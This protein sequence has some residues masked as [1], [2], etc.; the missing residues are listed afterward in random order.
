MN[1]EQIKGPEKDEKKLKHHFYIK[2][3]TFETLIQSTKKFILCRVKNLLSPIISV[4]SK[5][6][7]KSTYFLS[8]YLAK[9]LLILLPVSFLACLNQFTVISLLKPFLNNSSRI[10]QNR[11]C[12]FPFVVLVLL[13]SWLVELLVLLGPICFS[14]SPTQREMH[15]YFHFINFFMFLPYL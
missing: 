4:G 6:F 7:H 8:Y 14:I 15:Y 9:L 5:M 12:S 2:A 11:P 13:S 10:R 3:E 1:L